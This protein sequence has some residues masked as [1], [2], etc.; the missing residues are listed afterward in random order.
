MR[1]TKSWE[2]PKSRKSLW[3]RPI[4]CGMFGSMPRNNMVATEAVKTTLQSGISNCMNSM[5][6]LYVTVVWW[7]RMKTLWVF[8]FMPPSSSSILLYWVPRG[9][10]DI[11]KA[12][13]KDPPW[14]NITNPLYASPVINITRFRPYSGISASFSL[15]IINAIKSPFLSLF[16]QMIFSWQ[17]SKW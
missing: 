13:L 15:W 1:V 16:F 9:P 8:R 5:F 14:Q 7:Y 11:R 3:L 2:V 17:Y 10:E 6:I 12:V 4:W